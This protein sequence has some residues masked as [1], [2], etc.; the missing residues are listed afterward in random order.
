[1]HSI[2]EHASN[3]SSED[4]QRSNGLNLNVM[5]LNV[6]NLDVMNLNV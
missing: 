5:N 1:M 2:D 6:L 3:D 4:V